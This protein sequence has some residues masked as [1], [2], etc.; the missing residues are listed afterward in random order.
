MGT[1]LYL[2]TDQGVVTVKSSDAAW[3]IDKQSLRNWN[4]IEVA[5]QPSAPRRA[6]AATRGDGVWRSDDYGESWTKPNRGRLGPGKVRC[7][8][9]D[10][11][12]PNTVY[13]GGE[14]IELWV[15]HDAA[16]T[17]ST[18]DSVRAFP[19][20]DSIDYP[21]A[22]VEPHI[23]DIVIDGNDRNTM[24]LNLQV[25]HLLKTTDGGATWKLLNK[26]VDA[27]AHTL[28][29]RKDDPKRLYLATGGHDYRLGTTPGRSLYR[30]QDGG[31]SWL[32]MAMEFEQ[33][34]SV[35]MVANPKNEDIVYSAVADGNPST[36]SAQPDGARASLIR[37]TDA[38]ATWHEL[39][40]AVE[41]RRNFPE[42]ISIDPDEPDNVFVATR[43][44][45]LFG[46]TDGGDTWESLGVQVSAVADMKAVHV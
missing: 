24:Y 43:K 28:V 40:A 9:I 17:W 16:E 30:S 21:V 33:E 37:S 25:G 14:P 42:A 35:P 22:A 34:Y 39:D 44:G 38:G 4:V 13:A 12:D 7:I 11:H 45:E 26:D 15:S 19:G 2:S 41:I 3:A 1:L 10:P 5:V 6:Y 23:R 36:W 20:I 31:E 46:S 8:T 18:V 27:D 29:S 32:P